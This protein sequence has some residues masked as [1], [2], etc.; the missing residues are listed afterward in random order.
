[1]SDKNKNDKNSI[2]ANSQHE[3]YSDNLSDIN[4]ELPILFFYGH[5]HRDNDPYNR[6][7]LSQWYPCNFHDE[8]GMEY[9]CTEQFMMAEKARVHQT[10]NAENILIRADIMNQT[11]PKAIKELGRKVKGFDEVHWNNLRYDIVVRGNMFKF[12][13]NE[14]LKKILVKTKSA[15]LV[16][17]SPYDKIWGIGLS[18]NQARRVN[19]KRWGMNLLGNALMEVRCRL[20]C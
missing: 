2:G 8:S 12:G 19:R 17:A 20:D 7:V 3:Y 4:G 9:N 15:E 10:H 14:E 5:T 6:H 18:E 1:M 11:S 13:Q 16:E